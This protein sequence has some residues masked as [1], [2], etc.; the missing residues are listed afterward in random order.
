MDYISEWIEWTDT[1]TAL[2]TVVK[3][4]GLNIPSVPEN[5]RFIKCRSVIV[6]VARE[7]S[8]QERPSQFVYSF[9]AFP[10]NI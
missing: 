6:M 8:L 2:N 3:Y 9:N 4:T 10:E 1:P 7:L 5:S